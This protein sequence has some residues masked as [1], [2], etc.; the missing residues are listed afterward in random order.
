MQF[1]LYRQMC[2]LCIIYLASFS[3]SAQI[4]PRY[5]VQ[6]DTTPALEYS[7]KP[8]LIFQ[9]ETE[10]GGMIANNKQ[11]KETFNDIYYNG[12]NL[13]VGWQT[14]PCSGTNRSKSGSDAY[15]Q[16][17][18]F[19]V[20]GVGLYSSTFHKPEIGTPVALYGFVAIPIRPAR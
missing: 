2:L 16:R 14:R 5:N 20:Y 13:R 10:N 19:P 15:H 6:K 9:L 11:V 7:K 1:I 18:N 3:V 8:L 4:Y 17:Y 12:I